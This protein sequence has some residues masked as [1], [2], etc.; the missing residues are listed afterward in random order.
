MT[1]GET[2]A[3]YRNS[4]PVPVALRALPLI[5]AAAAVLVLPLIVANLTQSDPLGLS[6]FREPTFAFWLALLVWAIA[7]RHPTRG[8][9]RLRDAMERVLKHPLFFRWMSSVM[10]FLFVACSLT[11]HLSFGTS[12]FDFSIFDDALA[13][14]LEGK[15]LHVPIWNRSFLT[16]H[17]SPI[18]ILLVPFRWAFP[19]PYMLLVLY[20]L[21]LWASVLPFRAL[22]AS[23]NTPPALV[24][25]L[26][27]LY[28]NA[29]LMISTLKYDFHVEALLP[30]AF[31][32]LFLMHRRA[33]DR[34]YWLL[35]ILNLMI[36]EDVAVYLLGFATYLGF[37]E[38]RWRRAGLTAVVCLLWLALL[39]LL[40]PLSATDGWEGY[41]FLERWSQWGE[42]PIEI[43]VAMMLQPIDLLSALLRVRVVELLA[44]LLF[45]PCLGRFG[46]MLFLLPWVI[47]TT[48]E[49]AQASLVTY[50]GIPLLAFAAA[51]AVDGMESRVFRRLA[52]GWRGMSIAALGLVLS[53]SHL[54]FPWIPS[55]RGEVLAAIEALPRTASVQAMPNLWPVLG[56]ERERLLLWPDVEVDGD[57]VVMWTSGRTWPFEPKEAAELARE[58]VASGRYRSVAAIPGFA[59]LV[60]E[61][62]R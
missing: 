61:P 20:P 44:C 11:R 6:R 1:V 62:S 55:Q 37:A 15:L 16:Q 48:S 3:R 25:L 59:V 19:S 52:T 26:S 7:R 17:F 18:L 2:I 29:P 9:V 45:L 51:A 27:L 56:H 22:L 46:W 57:T 5:L 8:L 43:L 30:L 32:S 58:L 40:T 41:R 39:P 21:V 60:R 4:L 47:N 24:N 54:S 33:L 49:T 42:T 28:L 10:L 38:K 53:V 35:L 50:Y 31:L 23:A 34:A 14:T 12:L 13:T 36:K